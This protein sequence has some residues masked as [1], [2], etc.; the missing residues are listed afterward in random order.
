MFSSH[1]H[2]ADHAMKKAVNSLNSESKKEM[3][4]LQ[5]HL[6]V[7]PITVQEQLGKNASR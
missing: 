4:A 7:K 3:V 5:L 6:E 2:N 1:R